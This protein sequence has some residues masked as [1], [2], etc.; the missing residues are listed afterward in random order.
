MIEGGGASVAAPDS[1]VG[2]GRFIRRLDGLGSS[3][4][5]QNFINLTRWRIIYVYAAKEELMFQQILIRSYRNFH[6]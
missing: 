6:L 1:A 3:S 4:T 5:F 2:I